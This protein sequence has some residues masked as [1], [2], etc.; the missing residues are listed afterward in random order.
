[1]R[2]IGA[3]ALVLVTGCS[4][5]WN[6]DPYERDGNASADRD[7]EAST[8]SSSTSS[9]GSSGDSGA[10]SGFDAGSAIPLEA[11]SSSPDASLDASGPCRDELEPNDSVGGAM[12]PVSGKTCGSISTEDDE[13][14]FYVDAPAATTITIDLGVDVR[15]L[16]SFG[17]GD[18]GWSQTPGTKTVTLSPGDNVIEFEA[19]GSQAGGKYV[20]VLP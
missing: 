10:S 11:G 3:I 17:N 18:T 7:G 9:G 20:L 14:W 8:S 4:L 16:V 15:V 12:E 19:A 1:M 5:V 2:R 6:M 13:D